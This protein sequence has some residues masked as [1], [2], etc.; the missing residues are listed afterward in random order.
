LIVAHFSGELH[1][2]SPDCAPEERVIQASEGRTT[3]SNPSHEENNEGSFG[4]SGHDNDFL[5]R[6]VKHICPWHTVTAP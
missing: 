1:N 6:D 4:L 5:W 3:W 2:T